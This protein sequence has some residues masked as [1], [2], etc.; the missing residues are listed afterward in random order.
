MFI[1]TS[2]PG[3]L[4]MLIQ[5]ILLAI[6][7]FALGALISV[8]P[9]TAKHAPAT[10]Q[11]TGTSLSADD[12]PLLREYRGVKLGMTTQEVRRKLGEPADKSD[13]QDFYNF[14]ETETAQVFYDESGKVKAVSAHF[15]GDSASN[16]PTPKALFGEDAPPKADGSVFK[17]VRYSGAGY[18][19]SYSR[20]AGDHTLVTVS[21]QKLN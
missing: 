13:E 3:Y 4:K 19:V 18:W 21:M 10:A 17:L 6:L 7:I 14:S 16:A 9:Q 12:Q 11:K 8:N 20:T 5:L 1:S 15:A 2:E